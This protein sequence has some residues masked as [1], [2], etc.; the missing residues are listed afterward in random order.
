MRQVT[1]VPFE[2]E[3]G[4][5]AFAS[6]GLW[7]LRLRSVTLVA[8]HARR[9]RGVTSGRQLLRFADA[10]DARAFPV[11]VPGTYAAVEADPTT[12]MP[13]GI[14]RWAGGSARVALASLASAARSTAR[15]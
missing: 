11:L 2:D 3:S 14:L 6:A 8:P 9:R 15:S 13:Y 4:T 5:V 1:T 7:W 10:L 12:R